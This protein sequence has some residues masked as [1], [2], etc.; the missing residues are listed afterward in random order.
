MA[1]NLANNRENF[2]REL[3]FK[4]IIRFSIIACCLVVTLCSKKAFW[5]NRNGRGA[6]AVVRRVRRPWPRRS[7]DSGYQHKKWY[8]SDQW[9]I[10]WTHGQK[11]QSHT[12]NQG[13][14]FELKLEKS[15]LFCRTR[16]NSMSTKRKR[17]SKSRLS[18]FVSLI[19]KNLIFLPNLNSK[20]LNWFLMFDWVKTWI[21]SKIERNFNI[22]IK[23]A[24]LRT[25]IK[26][27]PRPQVRNLNCQSPHVHNFFR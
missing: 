26:N 2:K 12:L 21:F 7:N 16:K 1:S 11:Q 5:V 23:L 13:C 15:R 27:S 19:S 24:E 3:C 18:I 14:K 6:Q 8:T 9:L 20:K 10:L 25:K 4:T 17:L 22:C